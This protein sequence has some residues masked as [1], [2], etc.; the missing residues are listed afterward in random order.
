MGDIMRTA[1]FKFL[2]WKEEITTLLQFF[3]LDTRS[4]V[5]NT[6]RYSCVK[7]VFCRDM[8]LHF[9]DVET[10]RSSRKGK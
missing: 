4:T 2:N 3:F 5:H 1:N 8:I 10:G 9:K 7:N 6:Y